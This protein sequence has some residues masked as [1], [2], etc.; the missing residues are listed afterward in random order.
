TSSINVSGAGIVGD[1]KVLINATHTWTGDLEFQLV[2]PNGTIVNLITRRGGS[3]DNFVNTVLDDQAANPIS[4]GT[5]PFTGSFRPEQ[6]LSAFHGIS[7]N[8]TW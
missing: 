7:G 8:G 6:P 4:A 1:V 3:G 2:G 5:A